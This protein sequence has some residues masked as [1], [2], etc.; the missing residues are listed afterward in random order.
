MILVFDLLLFFFMFFLSEVKPY[1]N[2]CTK[3]MVDHFGSR[4]SVTE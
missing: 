4:I 2:S 1:R 3:M